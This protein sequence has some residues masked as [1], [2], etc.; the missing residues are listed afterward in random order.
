MPEIRHEM[1]EALQDFFQFLNDPST[2]NGVILYK[3]HIVIPRL[4]RDE[5]LNI[6]HAAHQG[7]TS[8][9]A[10]AEFSVFWPGITPA[11]TA[12]RFNCN[13]CNRNAPSN[14]SASPTT[15]EYP[16]QCISADYFMY[17]GHDYLVVV[18]RYSNWPIVERSFH[19]A[20]GLIS[21]LRWVFVTYGIPDKLA[22][23]GGPQFTATIT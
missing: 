10:R 17:K 16:F 4:L 18:D 5:V 19:G 6:L 14:Q 13:H 12:L 7:V 15:P 21:C 9:I 2:V 8:M 3:D 11:I 23:D 1:P 20:D 22:S